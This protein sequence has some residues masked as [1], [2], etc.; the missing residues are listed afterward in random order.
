MSPKRVIHGEALYR[1]DKLA[2]VEPPRFR[3]EYANLLPLALANGVFEANPLKVWSNVYSY[4]RPDYTLEDV[5]QMLDEYE[6]V[7]MLFRWQEPDGK[8]WG[9][10]VGIDKP[11]RLPGPSRQGKNEAIGPTPPMESIRKFLDSNGFHEALN[12]N[13]K[14][15]G[16]GFGSGFGSGKN[17]SSDAGASDPASLPTNTEAGTL[18]H[19]KTNDV[20]KTPKATV[21]DPP[22]PAAQRLAA[23]L[24]SE[25]FHN[26]PDMKI[27]PL[28]EAQWAATADRMLRIDKRSEERI[29]AVILWAQG[30]SFW[31]KN[32]LSMDKLRE[33]FDQLELKARDG[34]TAP[35]GE[36][37]QPAAPE[38]DEWVAPDGRDEKAGE[39]LWE[40]ARNQLKERLDRLAFDTWLKPIRSLG[41]LNST[42]Y[43]RLPTVEHAL[44]GDR[45]SA[46]LTHAL[47][48]L[49]I[50][51]VPPTEV[52][53]G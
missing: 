24:R 48:G 49:K 13:G 36:V 52:S 47:P 15:L 6:R 20:P 42:L 7:K 5:A 29:T 3:A 50:E 51:F 27:T 23:L 17:L 21:K 22:S 12:G 26:K 39:Q 45:F 2:A 38:Q 18:E 28:Q 4:N 8:V 46:E 40:A 34:T 31:H 35:G 41:L 11:G 10:F 14:L 33:K 37:A 9:F 30:D 19:P 25:I 44:V 43:L 1:S 53:R 32:I 16:F